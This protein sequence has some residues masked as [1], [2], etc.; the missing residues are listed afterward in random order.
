MRVIFYYPHLYYLSLSVIGIINP[1]G[2]L[3]SSQLIENNLFAEG[4]FLDD[5]FQVSFKWS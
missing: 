3:S 4:I 1:I 5:E 2:D